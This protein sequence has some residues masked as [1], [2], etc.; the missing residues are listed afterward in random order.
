VQGIVS[1]QACVSGMVDCTVVDPEAYLPYDMR[2]ETAPPGPKY[3]DEVFTPPLPK[4][5]NSVRHDSCLE[6]PDRFRQEFPSFLRG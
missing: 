2:I 1:R 5:G 3:L 4:G 6:V